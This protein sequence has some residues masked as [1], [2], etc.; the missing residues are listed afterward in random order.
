[1]KDGIYD[2]DAARYYADD[3]DSEPTLNASVLKLVIA[4]S[5]RHGWS[6]HPRLNP[7]HA[8]KPERKFDL[9]TV[10]HDVFLLDDD[11][12]V[13][14]VEAADWR[15]NAAK[16]VRDQAR[17]ENMVPLLVHEWTAV[18]QMLDALRD[19][20]P[21]LELDPPMFVGG[22]PEQTIIWTD[23]H[24]VRC[25]ARLDYLH[26]DFKACDDL[27]TC[28]GSAAPQAWAARTLFGMQAEIQAA[29]TMRG[30]EK[31]TGITPEFRFLAVETSPP[32]GV[33]PVRLAPS[34]LALAYDQIERGLLKWRRCLDSGIWPSYPPAIVDAEPPGWVQQADWDAQ[35][36][37]EAA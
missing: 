11:S 34:A 7:A 4:R 26:D 18:H 30:V 37:E 25:R 3:L 2:L 28:K 1:M 36:W 23:D 32:Y 29:L 27:K 6:A 17:E 15:T 35:A 14:V 22:R 16:A 13:A 9:G 20:L 12:R 33:C 8:P 24:D 10:A 21:G 19:Q 5:A 31:L